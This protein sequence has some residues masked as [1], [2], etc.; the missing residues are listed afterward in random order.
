MLV[1]CKIHFD[2]SPILH[3]LF[4]W[5]EYMNKYSMMFREN[6]LHAVTINRQERVALE[7]IKLGITHFAGKYILAVFR[8]WQFP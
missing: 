8:Q 1:D 6:T 5:H 7:M 2:C 4:C 3:K